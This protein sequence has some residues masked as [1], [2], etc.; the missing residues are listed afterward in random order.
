[1][2]TSGSVNSSGYEGRY[3]TFSWSEK[4]QSIANN[5]TTIS[6]TLKGAGTGVS[7]YYHA[8][9]IKLTLDG[10]TVYYQGEGTGSNYIKLYNGT[11]VASGEYT[12][13][14]NSDGTKKFKAYIEA[15]I[16]VWEVNC[17]GSSEFTLD[18]IARKS[19]LA[20]SN[21]TLGSALT[22]TVTRQ[23]TSLTHTITYKCGSASG[24][25]CTKSSNTSISWTPPVSL[26]SQNTTGLSVSIT[27][28][29]ATY[30]GDT[31]I[32]SNTKTV[33]CSIP[34]SVKP[35]ASV[36]VTNRTTAATGGKYVQGVSKLTITTIGIGAEGST[37][38]SCKVTFDGKTYTSAEGNAMSFNF[39][40]PVNAISGSGDLVISVT[41]TDSRGRT[42]TASKTITVVAYTPPVI[43]KLTVHRCDQDGTANDQGAYVEAVLSY[44]VSSGASNSLA[45]L[46]YKK[47]SESAYTSVALPIDDQFTVTD[48]SYIF[49]A[50]TGSSY[51]V[52][53][54]V[55]DDYNT[56]KLATSA[57]TAY[58][59]L[60][61]G[62]DGRSISVGKISEISDLFDIGMMTRFMGGILPPILEPETN[63][64]NVLTP[65]TYIG[66]NVTY[67]KYS[68]CPLESGTFVLTVEGAGN[69]DQIRQRLTRCHKTEPTAWERF[70]YSDD[71][72]GNYTWGE[73]QECPAMIDS[74]WQTLSVNS[75]LF[76]TYDTSAVNAVRCR[77]IGKMVEVRGI[78]APA[79]EIAGSTTSHVIA[80]LPT[81]FR[82]D[83]SVYTLCQGSGNCVWVL[84][85]SSNGSIYFSRYRNG[86]T[87]TTIQASGAWLPFHITFFVN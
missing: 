30:S 5:T 11:V 86:G 87:S 71:G 46:E 58:T 49:P 21:G 13:T 27:F 77:K 68:N 45:S 81:G 3:L 35:T 33:T 25:I 66:A 65:N 9:N 72:D 61:F 22:L 56:V 39:A 82:P 12:F 78:V 79:V 37:I 51:D 38:K 40:F 53:A 20:A 75:S 67:H 28:T 18:T 32:G 74:G 19:T 29:I 59:I 57:S 7:G 70:Y 8:R 4:S 44:K 26:A 69:A 48:Y 55:S 62:A 85:V 83:C 15:G 73:W 50:D 10:K 16:Y 1:M 2:A 14:H 42:A 54:S 36:G 64:N 60:H 52:R 23:S 47:A 6:W 41:V 76:K 63:L 34:S 84:Q 43:S 24:T 80:T 17:T 31:S